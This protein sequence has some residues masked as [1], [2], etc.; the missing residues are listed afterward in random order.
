MSPDS[1]STLIF[2]VTIMVTRVLS[3]I[4]GLTGDLVS[5]NRRLLADIKSNLGLSYNDD[6]KKIY[7]RTFTK[8]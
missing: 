4:L 7:K 8:R 2:A 1:I 6:Y 3:F 5:V